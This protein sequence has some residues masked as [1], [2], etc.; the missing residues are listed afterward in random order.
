MTA[1]SAAINAIFRDANMA[2]DAVYRACNSITDVPCRVILS[3]PDETTD[4]GA[5][6]V[7]SDTRRIDVRLSEIPAVTEGDLFTVNGEAL[8][9]QGSPMR[10]RLGLVWKIEAVP[11]DRDDA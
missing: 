3:L 10:D 7:V 4:Y 2:A 9:V 11:Q 6:S 1:F 5:H 8:V